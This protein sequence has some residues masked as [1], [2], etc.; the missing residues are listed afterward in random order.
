MTG[1]ITV[2]EN[3]SA[4]DPV[5]NS[6]SGAIGLSAW[7]NPAREASALHLRLPGSGDVRVSVYDAAGREIALVH[8]G[9]LQSGDHQLAWNGKTDSGE[10]AAS[11]IYFVRAIGAGGT[12]GLTLILAR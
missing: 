5:R 6:R 12:A 8:Q 3:P 1:T 4:A 10:D 7:P 9:V 2:Q 11:G